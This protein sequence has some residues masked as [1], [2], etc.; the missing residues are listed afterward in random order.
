M[1]LS[2]AEKKKI[3]Q[4]LHA[5]RL[6]KL[7]VEKVKT[8]FH[9]LPVIGNVFTACLFLDKNNDILSRGVSICSPLDTFKR[10]EGRS[11]AYKRA[12]RALHT[13]ID[14][15]P[16]NAYMLRFGCE[17]LK[18]EFKLR[19]EEDERVIFDKVV[20][21]LN[22]VKGE[23]CDVTINTTHRKKKTE[24]G[25]HKIV[26]HRAA[27]YDLPRDITLYLTSEKFKCKACY[28]PEPTKDEVNLIKPQI[29]V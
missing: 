2:K 4:E 15:F 27:I 14:S 13:K 26:E 10:A 19:T 28:K 23:Y 8:Y 12:M 25:G 9:N 16:I 17:D 18:R 29:E 24:N 3:K 11:R 20:P 22:M 7:G 6:K 1:K 5:E 21:I